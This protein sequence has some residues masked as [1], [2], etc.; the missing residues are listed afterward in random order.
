M[1][2]SHKYQSEAAVQVAARRSKIMEKREMKEVMEAD[3]EVDAAMEPSI[4]VAI[5]GG[6][7]MQWR[8]VLRHGHRCDH[9]A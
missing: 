4:V 2:I 1:G 9:N 7:G 8:V 3:G 5:A 6:G